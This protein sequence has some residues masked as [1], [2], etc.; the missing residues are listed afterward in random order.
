MFRSATIDCIQ[1]G[2]MA[3]LAPSLPQQKKRKKAQPGNTAPS[4]KPFTLA[5]MLG[6]TQVAFY[7]RAA[8]AIAKQI[9]SVN[10]RT[11]HIIR[12]WSE[13]EN[14]RDLLGK[15]EQRFP[16]DKF[17]HYGPRCVFLEH[18]IPAS[19]DGS[20]PEIVYNQKALQQLVDWA[21]YRIANSDLFSAISVGHTPSN[22]E[23]QA[24]AAMPGVLGYAGPFYLGQFGNI[25]PVW[26]IYADEWVHL[27][28]EGEFLKLQRRSPEVWC[29]EPM[30]RRTMDPIAALGAETPR[31]DCGMNATTAYTRAGDD[32]H[33]MKYSAATSAVAAIPGPSNSYVP[34]GESSS[35]KRV[36]KVDYSGDSNMPLPGVDNDGLNGAPDDGLAEKIGAAIQ[37]LLPSLV[38]AVVAQIQGGNEDELADAGDDAGPD[39]N[40]DDDTLPSPRGMGDGDADDVEGA[41][42]SLN[43]HDADNAGDG[44]L[45]NNQPNQDPEDAKYRAMGPQV[46]AAYQAGCK[47]AMKY[48]RSN[49]GVDSNLSKIVAKQANDIAALK[50]SIAKKDQD[51]IRYSRLSE[52]AQEYAFDPKDEF[53]GV[54]DF[55]D[56]QF[57]RHCTSTV[58]KY[59]RRDDLGGVELYEDASGEPMKY[60]RQAATG[61]R[62]TGVSPEQIERY[63]REASSIAARKNA[64]KRGSTTF[65]AEFNAICQ[66]HGVTV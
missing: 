65:E 30:E 15:A 20:R 16:R 3:T 14:A 62:G 21:N 22:A 10:D 40:G 24:G 6:E 27:A 50:A 7:M 43:D 5:P 13:S 61:G 29:D 26:A 47:R 63:S 12:L 56:A 37:G 28:D 66:R 59:Q 2:T 33:V 23:R 46:Y 35:R 53:E 9:P 44:Q 31:L 57:E 52:L 39:V 64:A 38:Q 60:G 17:V 41:D 18:T 55:S 45:S 11:Q 8:R 19:N 51:V 49:G 25:D 48:S 36:T 34:G 42:E 32:R 58:T 1:W 4:P 54:A